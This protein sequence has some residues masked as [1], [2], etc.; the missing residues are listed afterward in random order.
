MAEV[1]NEAFEV[2]RCSFSMSERLFFNYPVTT[3]D[4]FPCHHQ[5]HFKNQ[6]IF[7]KRY[8]LHSLIHLDRYLAINNV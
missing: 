1:A 6:L 5:H 8:L 4:F 3:D 2:A 7:G